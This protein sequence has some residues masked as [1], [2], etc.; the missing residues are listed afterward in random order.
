[1]TVC[2]IPKV[3]LFPVGLHKLIMWDFGGPAVEP[4]EVMEV[5]R[6]NRRAIL[7]CCRL[8]KLV[9]DEVGCQT[10]QRT[11]DVNDTK[12][13]LDGD[14]SRKQ[15]MFRDSESAEA[16]P[17][18][19]ASR[20]RSSTTSETGGLSVDHPLEQADTV[21]TARE[22]S[23]ND[24]EAQL[25]VLP[26]HSPSSS[27]KRYAF[28]T[29]GTLRKIFKDL[30]SPVS[31]SILIAFPITL[32][33]EIKALFVSVPGTPMPDAPDG[34]P[35]LSFVLDV[36]GFIGNS[37]VPLALICLGSSLARLS[38]PK[39]GEWKKLPLGAIG[40]LAVGKLL[41][42]PIIGV[43]TCEGLTKVG[44]ISKD[45]KVLRFICM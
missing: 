20:N 16:S 10:R 38:I 1:M 19:Q 23:S 33:P 42:M 13:T 7:R 9:P 4:D 21:T 31:L 43:L 5:T 37:A 22:K 17:V 39:K 18:Q 2:T 32:I 27:C 26:C 12:N 45:D 30:F 35:P 14:S 15:I 25:V 3:T 40:S 29:F 11:D 36:T 6:R 28:S 44:F 24:L 34:Q 8:S 41:I